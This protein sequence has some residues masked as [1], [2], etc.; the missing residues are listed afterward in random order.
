MQYDVI[1]IGGGPAG[2]LAAG[3]AGE[4]GRRVLLIEKNE[5]LG[6]KLFITGKGRCNITNAA[7]MDE[8]MSHIPKNSKFLYSAFRGFSNTD[9]ISML[10]EMGL[11]TKVERGGRVFPESDKSSDVLKALQKF[12]DKNNVHVML[13]TA[14]KD[15]IEKD[16]NIDG[17]LL[18]DG[19]YFHS[20]SVIVCTGGVSYPQTGSTGDGLKFAK[21]AGH[22]ITDLFPSL[23]PLVVKEDY[24]KELQGLSL[25]NV[26]I[27][28]LTDNKPIYNDF[29]EMLFTHYG[30]SGP[31]ILSASFYISEQLRNNQNIRVSID[32]KPALT[33]EELDKRVLKDFQEKIN[34]NFKN[35]LD[36]LLPQ[37]LIPVIIKL[38]KIDETKEVNQISKD[39]RKQLV[40]LLKNLEFN[41]AGTRPIVE[42]IVTSGGVSLKEVN[43]KT[44]ESK[45]VRGLYFAGEVLDL[46]AFTG[47]YNLQIAF[48]TGYAAGSNA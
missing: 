30:L 26:A 35:S 47:G 21:E 20:E 40:S 33:E 17:V 25:K 44:L 8:F 14:V 3:A 48:S 23:I 7:E 31:I 38:S 11:K 45:L 39:E 43:P 18:Q 32:L 6:K 24:I 42:A 10:N 15:V 29:G 27:T 41:I 22:T 46:D 1:V 28:V 34:K 37:K 4:R 9:I 5:K 12:L 2:I 16:G 19:R 36:A 13:N